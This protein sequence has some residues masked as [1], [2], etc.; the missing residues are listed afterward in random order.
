MAA[1]EMSMAAAQV[2]ASPKRVVSG[3]RKQGK[4]LFKNYA[5]ES[6]KEDRCR[7]LNKEYQ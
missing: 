4:A 2:E 3:E 6:M 1:S 5:S 7:V